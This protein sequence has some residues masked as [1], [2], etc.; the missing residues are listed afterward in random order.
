M[1]ETHRIL[2]GT[3]H[4]ISTSTL[5]TYTYFNRTFDDLTDLFIFACTHGNYVLV[6]KLLQ[7][8]TVKAD[9]SNKIGKSALQLAIENEHDEVVKILLDYIPYEQYR[10]ALLLSIYLNHTSIA[11]LILNHPIYQTFTG[12]FLNPVDPEAYDDSQFSS[13]ITPLILAAQYNRLPIIHYLLAQGERIEKPHQNTCICTKCVNNSKLDSFRQSQNRLSAYKGLA[14]EVYIALLYP[15]PILHA[16]QLGQELRELAKIEHYFSADYKKLAEQL[17]RFVARLLDN[18]RGC[19]EL[20]IVLNKTGLPNEEKYESLARFDLAIQYREKPFVS[21]S[22]CQQ[23]LIDNWYANLSIIQNTDVFKRSLFYLAYFIC[24]PFLAI[25]YYLFPKSRMGSLCQQPNLKFKAYIASYLIFIILNIASSYFSA[26]HIKTT[27]FLSDYDQRL[28]TNYIQYIYQNTELRNYINGID[29]D[30]VHSL[31]DCDISLRFFTP[32]LF[33]I[34]MSIWVIGFSW[35]EFKQIADTGLKVYLKVASNYVD[36]S[37]NILYILYFIFLYSS[38]IFTRLAMNIFQ[39][40]TYWTN[41]ARYSTMTNAEKQYYISQTRHIL[42]W[43]NADRFYWKATDLNNLAEAFFAMGIVVSICRMCF[44]LPIIPFVGPLQVMLDYMMIDISKWIF[45]IV[46][47]F[48]SFACALFSIFSYFAVNLQ[49]QISL[50]QTSLNVN[51]S[52][53]ISNITLFNQSTCSDYFYELLNGSIP[54]IMSIVEDTNDINNANDSCQQAST[55]QLYQNIETYPAINYFGQSF[56]S[57]LLTTFFTLFGVIGDGTSNRGYELQADSSCQSDPNSYLPGFDNFVSNLGFIIYGLFTFICITVLINTLIAMLEET[58]KDIDNRAD[59]EW[60][61]ARSKLYMEYIRNGNPLP[62]P[63]NILPTPTAINNFF[64]YIKKIILRKNY[65]YDNNT[66]T[67]VGNRRNSDSESISFDNEG[68]F[69]R[70]Q[71]YISNKKLTY[72]KV[73]ERVIKRFLLYYKDLRI[74]LPDNKD[75]LKLREL[76]NDVFALH[77]ELTNN[78]DEFNE[79]YTSMEQSMNDFN[80]TLNAYFDLQHI[81]EH[82]NNQNIS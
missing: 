30:T 37:M 13:D 80:T 36:C 55:Y 52:I 60:K 68:I 17:S 50:F 26:N 72:K 61:Y 27:R 10:D 8:G 67:S 40:T 45:I 59:I 35:N 65:S 54:F 75:T 21:H 20:E 73:I 56:D 5:T 15:D 24:F 38:M 6:Y 29:N 77:F 57:T 74:G 78:I 18:I 3:I 19:E 42:Y 49:Q 7:E 41:L 25:T 11:N 76:Q 32:N 9:S 63:L 14:S 1:T 2:H 12:K 39:S 23:N 62:V 51:S 81:K 48:I 64:H 46:I 4:E 22:N 69:N 43:L 34:A 70:R 28:Y 53:E 66:E 16:F 79:M 31:V 71:S 58:I 82:F 44:L 33:Q 47:F